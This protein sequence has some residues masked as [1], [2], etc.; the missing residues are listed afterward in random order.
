P[1]KVSPELQEEKGQT[2]ITPDNY[3]ILPPPSIHI[4]TGQPVQIGLTIQE[5]TARVWVRDQG[6][7]L[8]RE[9]QKHLW[10][11]FHQAKG[12]PVQSGSSKGLG[13]GLYICQTLIAQHQG[14]VGVDSTPGK[15]STFW[16]TLPLPK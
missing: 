8:T 16:F 14:T 13:L 7:G 5:D 3:Q 10:Q 9:D 11:R 12:V 2:D 4:Y 6:P 1:A 15:G